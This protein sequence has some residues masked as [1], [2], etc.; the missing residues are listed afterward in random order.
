MDP[1]FYEGQ[2]EINRTRINDKSPNN[3]YATLIPN[4]LGTASSHS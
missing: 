4:Q 2:L 3:P 1:L